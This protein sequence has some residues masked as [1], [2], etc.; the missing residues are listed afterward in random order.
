MTVISIYPFSVWVHACVKE[1]FAINIFELLP[2]GTVIHNDEAIGTKNKDDDEK[3]EKWNDDGEKELMIC[4]Q[5]KTK[6]NR[7][8]K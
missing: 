8:Q 1:L 7:N 4:P 3:K 5:C 2:N 6:Q